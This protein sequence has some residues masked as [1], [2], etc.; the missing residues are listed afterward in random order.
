MSIKTNRLLFNS[1]STVNLLK[2]PQVITKIITNPDDLTLY[3]NYN[4]K[5]HTELELIKKLHVA[6]KY[7][8]VIL[9]QF[10]LR[11]CNVGATLCYTKLF[12]LSVCKY[13]SI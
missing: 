11:V 4:C 9:P 5:N 1:H 12:V 8:T 6:I 3:F 7:D 2:R 13:H 10:V